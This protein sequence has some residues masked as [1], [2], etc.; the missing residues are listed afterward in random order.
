MIT[1]EPRPPLSDEWGDLQ[2]QGKVPEKGKGTTADRAEKNKERKK[3]RYPSEDARIGRK[4]SPT[5]SSPLVRRLQAICKVEG[6]VSKNGSGTIV[7]SVIE[8][9]LWFAVEAYERGEL[10][11]EEE[12]VIEVRR[13]LRRRAR[14]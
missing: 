8:D 12:Q 5:L 4:I 11:S 9:L 10:E 7:S 14:K 3:P 13:R 6:H 1:D 2:Q